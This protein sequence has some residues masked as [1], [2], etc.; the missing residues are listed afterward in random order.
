MPLTDAEWVARFGQVI[1]FGAPVQVTLRGE[2][3]RVFACRLCI[4]RYGLRGRE[5]GE[6][7]RTPA[8]WLAHMR[9]AHPAVV[10][11]AGYGGSEPAS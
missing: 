11:A 8:E 7:P 3:T 4:A 6:L 9:A 2:T 5:V 1:P 10:V